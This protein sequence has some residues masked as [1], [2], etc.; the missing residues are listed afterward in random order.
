MPYAIAPLSLLAML[1]VIIAV[2]ELSLA[3]DRRRFRCR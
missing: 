1:L 2:H 3:A